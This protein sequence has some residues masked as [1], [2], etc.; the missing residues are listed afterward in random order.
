VIFMRSYPR[1]S[2]EAAARIV[3]LAL[4]ADGHLGAKE[5]ALL[6]RHAIAE[7]LGLTP[8]QLHD[9]LRAFCEDLQQTGRPHWASVQVVDDETLR[10]LLAE[11][12]DPGLRLR[13][14][15]WCRHIVQADAHVSEGE[16][17]LLRDMVHHWSHGTE[18]VWRLAA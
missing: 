18:T 11:I 15:H 8:A 17:Q 4:L 2:P 7:Q 3:V 5:T 16:V 12:D 10:H 9:V 14:M 13:L 1:N 6:E